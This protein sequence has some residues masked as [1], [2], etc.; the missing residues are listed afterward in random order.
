MNATSIEWTDL[1]VNIFRARLAGTEK[2]KGGYAS[3]VGHYCEKV[4]QGC[5]NCYSST[6]QP[7]F[8]LPQFQN[9]R[10]GAVEV[11]FDA[12]KAQEVLARR[13]PAR[14]FWNDMTDG[15][16]DWIPNEWIAAW[17]GV[18]AATPQHTHQVLT[19]R[20]ERM[21]AWF[22]WAERRGEQ[23]TALFPDDP[24]DWRIRQMMHVEARR[25]GVDLNADT[26]QNHGG[27]WPLPNV[28]LGVSVED[29][30]RADERISVLL[31]C[32]AAVRWISAEP[33]LEEISLFAFLTGGLRNDC[34]TRLGSKN[35]VPSL[36]WVVVGGESGPGARP[37]DLAWARSIVGQCRAA[38]TPVFVKQLGAVPVENLT[39][40]GKFRNHPTDGRRQ[41]EMK[42]DRVRLADRKGGDMSEWAADLQVREMPR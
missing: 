13:K 22:R 27:P 4:S 34:L 3:G 40:T 19:K 36:D 20:A 33:L 5:A 15:F 30:Q 32:P 41:F 2:T 7:R 31:D 14:I 9:Q 29:Q 26:H 37:F 38:A 28:H 21:L 16:G 25:R 17:F 1:T 23:G 8:G 35:A 24:L 10:N 42:A 18:M 6:L 39:V 11:F 12:E